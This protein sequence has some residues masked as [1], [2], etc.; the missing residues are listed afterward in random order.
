MS[1]PVFF[2]DA[3]AF[4]R[5]L[6]E[7]GGT[8]RELRVGFHKVGSG[9][10]S[11]R[12]SESVDEALCHG[13]IDG[14][15][16]RIDDQ[17]YQIR[18]TPRRPDSI[19]SAVNLAKVAQLQAQGRMRPAGQAAFDRRR[20]DKSVVYAY[21]QAEVA[22]L[23]PDE[24]AQLRANAAAWAWWERAAPSY[25]KLALH[26]ITTARKPETRAARLARL[27]AAC[28]AGERC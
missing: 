23:R 28:A 4:G 15:R 20:V 6:A 10:P 27:I 2:P 26:R 17:R 3:A 1:E 9:Q 16:Q 7:H 8:A 14:V 5:W 11:L 21:E 13:W 25:R 22:L 18:F 24:E 12:W 19:W